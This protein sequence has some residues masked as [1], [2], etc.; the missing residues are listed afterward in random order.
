[1]FVTRKLEK[2]GGKFLKGVYKIFNDIL[3][4]LLKKNIFSLFK[5]LIKKT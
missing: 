1:M 2:F 4:F 5:K 3:Y